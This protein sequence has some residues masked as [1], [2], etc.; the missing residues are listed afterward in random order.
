MGTDPHSAAVCVCTRR[1]PEMLR[2]CLD[3]LIAQVPPEGWTVT[4]IVVEND[5][6]PRC[7]DIVSE[8][9]KRT[10]YPIKYANETD[11]GIPQARNRAIDASRALGAEWVAFIDDDEVADPDWLVCLCRRAEQDGVDVVHGAL[12]NEYPPETPDW[13]PRRLLTVRENGKILQT[14]STANV[15]F[16]LALTEQAGFKLRFD[17]SLRFTGGED[18]DF[19]HRAT[20]RGARIVWEQSA[21]VSEIIRPSRVRLGWQLERAFWIALINSATERRRH[22]L[23]RAFI[24]KLPKSLSRL[25]KAVVLIPFVVLWPVGAPFR[26]V[27]FKAMKSC[28]SGLGGLAGLTPFRVEP[29]RVIDGQ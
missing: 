25:I 1:R 20:E 14:A 2:A 15:M 28:A 13:L 17:T 19:F 27:A 24:R 8:V 22:G 7:I 4:L 21:V 9:K 16:R 26:R 29:Y 5:D 23:T 11:L 12:R 3:S 18:L 10:S 6:K